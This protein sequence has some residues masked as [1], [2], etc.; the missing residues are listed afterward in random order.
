M[1]KY[2]DAEL[3]RNEIKRRIEILKKA[4]LDWS[5]QGDTETSLYYSGKSVALDEFTDFIDSL[6]QELEVMD[7]SFKGGTYRINGVEKHFNS[8]TAKVAILEINEKRNGTE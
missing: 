1:A 2:I 3:L 6:Q 7:L 4:E 8:G 5:K